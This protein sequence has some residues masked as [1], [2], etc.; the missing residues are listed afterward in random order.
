[1]YIQEAGLGFMILG[2]DIVEED[3]N[4][5]IDW[6]LEYSF[7]LWQEGSVETE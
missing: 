7:I 5:A 4:I 2:E 3:E 6:Y 1:M